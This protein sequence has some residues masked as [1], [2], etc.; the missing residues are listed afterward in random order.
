M[1]PIIGMSPDK[2]AESP[3]AQGVCGAGT[4]PEAESASSPMATSLDQI[5]RAGALSVVAGE[6]EDDEL[7]NLNWL[8]ENLLQN[9]TL[10]GEAQPINSPLFD[11]EGGGGSP[12]SNTTSST[13]S[14]SAGSERDP[15]KSKP[16]FSFSLLIYMAIEQSPSKSLP[17][18]DIYGWIL[19]HFPYFSS[20]P[21][22]WKNSVRHNL[23]LNKC[24]RKVER[25]I[26]KTNGKGSLWCVHPEFRPMLMQALKKQHF[27]NA[28]AFCTPP[29]SPPSASSPPHHLF[30]SEQGCALKDSDDQEGPIDLSRRDLVVVSRDP[31]QDHNYSSTPVPP[32]PRQMPLSQPVSFSPALHRDQEREGRARWPRSPLQGPLLGKRSRRDSRPDLDEELKEAA[33]SLLHLAGIRTSLVA[34]RRKSRKLSRK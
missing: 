26:G 5:G 9:F 17:V 28:H 34:S 25:S 19:K 22:G 32:C 12:H 8:H 11:I 10:G 23:S 16:P 4:L 33:G 14:V 2:K 30:T 21:T 3:G 15:Y 13:S 18:K 20:A 24:F 27:P 1:G 7:T 31:K 6:S 29:A